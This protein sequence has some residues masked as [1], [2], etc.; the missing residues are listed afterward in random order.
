[1]IIARPESVGIAVDV[2]SVFVIPQ[3][4]PSGT[5]EQSVWFAV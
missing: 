2:M 3:L 5:L 4:T 1:M